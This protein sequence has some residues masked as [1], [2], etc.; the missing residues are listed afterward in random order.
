MAGFQPFHRVIG[1]IANKPVRDDLRRLD[2]LPPARSDVTVG[3]IDTGI[4][5]D[6]EGKPPGL[7][8][9]RPPGR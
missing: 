6:K 8:R 4:V 3:V 1:G 2:E 7:V 9:D 5:V